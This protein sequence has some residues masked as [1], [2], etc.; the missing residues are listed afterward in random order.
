MQDNRETII[1]AA[2]EQFNIHG[3]QG[4]SIAM[5]AQAAHIAK[6]TLYYYFQAKEDL[7]EGAFKY[8]QKNAKEMALSKIDFDQS[9]E[10]IVKQLV[11]DSLIW[12]LQ[13]PEQLRYMDS[14]LHLYFYEKE[15]YHLFPLGVFDE[16]HLTD[17]LRSALKPG[18]PLDMLN[19]MVGAMLTNLC[20][21]VIINPEY[22]EDQTFIDTVAQSV[23]DMVSR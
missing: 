15:A 16:E 5:I 7:I 3:I 10:R 4:A 8:V 22:G 18:L 21:Y 19:T 12:P 6:G 1:L 17:R 13:Y 20:K 23:W 2:I 11:R 9:A 14:Y